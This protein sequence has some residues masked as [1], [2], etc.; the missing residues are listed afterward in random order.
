M[1][2]ARH[3]KGIVPIVPAKTSQSGILASCSPRLRRCV[4]PP[5]GRA[6]RRTAAV[7][8]NRL[9][10]NCVW[11]V[12]PAHRRCPP[13]RDALHGTPDSSGAR[14]IILIG[15]RRVLEGSTRRTPGGLDHDGNTHAALAPLADRLAS[16]HRGR[17]PLDAFPDPLP[18]FSLS[19]AP[20][21][22][23]LQMAMAW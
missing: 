20:R 12:E 9:R 18:A 16:Y 11:E 5:C 6:C 4:A 1:D 14:R 8:G 7:T 17:Q 3:T 10:S 13:K 19:P 22:R 2:R 23:W 21:R 15:A